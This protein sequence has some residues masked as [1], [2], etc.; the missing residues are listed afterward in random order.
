MMNLT[1]GAFICVEGLDGAGKTSNV[2]NIASFLS[3]TGINHFVASEYIDTKFTGAVRKL[4]NE[5]EPPL[6]PVTETMMFYASRIEHTQK[7]IVPYIDKG[8]HVVCDRY[9]PSTLSYQ[10]IHNP[11]VRDVHDLVLPRLREPD[12]IFLYDIPV[13]VYEERV[14]ARGKGLDS[15]EGRGVEYF[16]Q[17]RANFHKLAE[18]DDRFVII[19]ASEPLED[20]FTKTITQLNT[21]LRKFN[22]GHIQP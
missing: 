19:D 17:V 9:Y 8:Y 4:L 5:Q 14:L 6:D 20:V 3:H 21:F 16:K 2:R 18:A 12:L 22:E 7:I 13:D 1:R 15:I 11:I 10:G